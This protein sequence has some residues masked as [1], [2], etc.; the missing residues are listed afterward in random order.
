MLKI[1]QVPHKVL[2]SPTKQVDVIDEK[3]KKLVYDMEETLVAQVDPQ[4]VGLA[5]TQVGYGLAIFIMK[6]S[7][8]ART[9]VCINPKILKVEKSHQSSDVG[10]QKNSLQT[11]DQRQ[12]TEDNKKL[13]GCLSIPR[14]WGP[15]KR[16]QK[17]LMEYQDLNGEKHSKWF[18]GFKATIVQHEVDHLQ[19][20]LFTQRALEQ[21]TTLYEEKDGELEK[22][23]Y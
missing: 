4:G 7:P 15:V 11:D 8:K 1:V 21:K 22:M 18:T 20:I 9:E 14:I 17:V 23:K 19:G 5:A 16:P 3:I 2:T 13:E 12:A 6:P 10:H